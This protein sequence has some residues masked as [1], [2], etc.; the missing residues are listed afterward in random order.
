[1]QGKWELPFRT[2][3]FDLRFIFGLLN[4]NLYTANRF[5]K[6]FETHQDVLIYLFRK[7]L[8]PTNLSREFVDTAGKFWIFSQGFNCREKSQ[9]SNAKPQW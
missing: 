7:A 6:W 1:V 8:V 3:N 5:E 2:V 9:Q 4:W